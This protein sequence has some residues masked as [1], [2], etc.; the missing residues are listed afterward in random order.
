VGTR[1][2]AIKLA[3]VTRLLGQ[4]A[5]VVH[6]GQ[7]FSAG[8]SG[9]LT[10]DIALDAH[11]NRDITRGHHLGN[12]VTASTMSSVNTRVMVSAVARDFR[13]PLQRVG[14]ACITGGIATAGTL[15]ITGRASPVRST[16]NDGSS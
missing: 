8:M 15:D 9:H 3:P 13:E 12:L 4:E 2:K 16:W 11:D 7:H 5:V 10:S 6:T 1:P 14:T